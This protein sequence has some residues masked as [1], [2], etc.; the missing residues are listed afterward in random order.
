M[1]EKIKV[2][3]CIVTY[4]NAEI[5]EECI[6]SLLEKTKNVDFQLYVVDNA[7]TDHTVSLVREKFPEVIVIEEK[8]NKG[9]GH[10]HNAVLAKIDSRYHAVL[11]PDIHIEED[12]ISALVQMME[13][14]NAKNKEDKSKRIVMA[15]PKILNDDYTE[16]HLPKKDPSIRYVI[17]SKFKPFRHYRDEYTRKAE[18]GQILDIDMCTGCFFVIRTALLKKLDGFDKRYF[19]YCED[20]DLSVRVRKHGRIVFYPLVSAVHKW[21]RENTR[22]IKGVVRFLTSLTKYFLRFGLNW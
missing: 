21:E 5:I 4:N 12:T 16:Q 14:E 10:G 3:G 20:A 11:N 13:E 18:Q 8:E 6:S 17:L 9:F 19:M 7:S 22:S 1:N 2:S 15:T